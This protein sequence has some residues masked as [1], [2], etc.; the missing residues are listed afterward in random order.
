MSTLSL[1]HYIGG[2]WTGAD[3]ALESLNPSNTGEV[4]ARF[5][6]GGAAEVGQAVAAATA[7]FPAWSSAS[8][9]VRADLLDKIAATIFARANEL[10]E[11]LA[12]EEGKTRAEGI[13]E[14]L[15]AARIFR[16]F[17]GEA[18]RRHGQTLESTRPGLDVAT[19]RE[20]LGV[21]GL[22]TPWNFPIAIPAWKAAPAL[23][24]GNTVVLKPANITPAVASAL[25]AIIHEC[26]VPAGVFNLVLGRGDVGRAITDNKDVAAVS[27]TGSQFVG[28]QVG[29]AAMAR[30]ARVQM[31]M[32]GKNPL[33]V[34]A[35]ADLD[36][37]VAIAADGGFFQTGQRCTASSRVIVEDAIHDRFVAA[38]AERAK[39]IK[40]GPALAE[41]TQVG[42][43]SS[44]AQFEQN[45]NY[46]GIATGEGGR[47]AAG[48]DKVTAE[49]PGYFLQPTL[50]ADTAPEMRI[51][52]EEVFGPVVS[53]VRVKN[54]EEAL[55][56][57]NR[58]DFGLSAGIVS[59][60][61]KHIRDFRKNVRAGMVM[62]N[63]PTAGV[64]YHVPFGGTRGSSYG[65][66]EQGFAAVEFYTQIKTVYTGD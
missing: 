56:V 2:E 3:D 40:V 18:L 59:N 15:R 23:A 35:D 21:V 38:L 32:G 60:N 14:T 57:A 66:R 49:T 30:Q 12:R 37:A 13:G 39:A 31:E 34:L 46:I 54:Y 41:G 51:N 33:V 19:Y 64:D 42:P 63:L 62:V 61:A 53:T 9:E 52:S 5:P 17:A 55:E 48:G 47:L 16:Y 43:A 29:A 25:T 44:E 65:P 20:A 8:P 1:G 10:G 4:V 24:F 11:L 50:I 36:K 27:F 28:A 7:A 6:N 58:G 45:L 22:I 26:G